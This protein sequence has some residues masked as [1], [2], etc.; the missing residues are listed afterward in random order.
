MNC[1][2]LALQSLER[3]KNNQIRKSPLRF[4]GKVATDLDGNR[5]FISDSNNHRI[6]IT[7]VEGKFL[8]QIGGNG[9]MLKDGSFADCSFNRP[10]V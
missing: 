3:E 8:D 1:T 7:T 10:Q 5:I 4:P 6:V 9:P 2:V